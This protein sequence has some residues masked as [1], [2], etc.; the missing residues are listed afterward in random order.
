MSEKKRFGSR[1]SSIFG[2]N[3]SN[4]KKSQPNTI[5]SSV[6][7]SLN[8]PS[9]SLNSRSKGLSTLSSPNPKPLNKT[10]LRNHA[11]SSTINSSQHNSGKSI[12]SKP[13]DEALRGS[14]SNNHSLSLPVNS[15]RTQHDDNKNFSY[16]SQ[17]NY[18]NQPHPRDQSINSSST[19]ISQTSIYPNISNVSVQLSPS[20]ENSK[21]DPS[22]SQSRNL[23]SPSPEPPT[24]HKLRR[25]PPSELDSFDFGN[26]N[27]NPN[28]QLQSPQLS[29][30]SKQSPQDRDQ[31]SDREVPGNI[32]AD[33]ESEIDHFLQMEDSHSNSNDLSSTYS[34]RKAISNRN[35]NNYLEETD[36]IQNEFMNDLNSNTRNFTQLEDPVTDFHL[37]R[38]RQE[39]PYPINSNIASPDD[40][41]TTT[42]TE[43]VENSPQII[44][45]YMMDTTNLENIN[46]FETTLASHA[47][48]QHFD[49]SS[50]NRSSNTSMTSPITQTK[51][52]YE[53]S[54]APSSSNVATTGV[55]STRSS[56]SRAT[57]GSNSRTRPF[58]EQSPS[59]CHSTQTSPSLQL[60][61][62]QRQQQVQQQQVQQQ[63]P[64]PHQLQQPQHLPLQQVTQTLPTQQISTKAPQL[65]HTKTENS[66]FSDVSSMKNFNTAGSSQRTYHRTSSSIGSI[67][68]SNSYRNVNL[69]T[70]KKTL[71]L[72][73]G[74]G[75]RSNYVLTIRRNAG[76]A[77]NE[78]GPSKWKLPVGIL[79]IDKTAMKDNSNGKYKR[80][81][82]NSNNANYRKK[83]SGVELKHGHLK[84]RLLA[85]EIDEGDDYSTSIT[86]N[87]TSPPIT[88][89][90]STTLKNATSGP[91]S[92]STKASR[93]N[94][95]KRTTTDGSLLTGDTQSLDS[96]NT[97]ST[98]N[99]NNGP[100]LNRNDSIVSS[101]SSGSISEKL[102]TGYYQ[103][104]GYKYGEIDDYDYNGSKD[105]RVD[106]DDDDATEMS[107]NCDNVNED[108]KDNNLNNKHHGNIAHLNGFG[109]NGFVNNDTEIEDRPKLVLANPDYSSDSD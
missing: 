42:P 105:N 16:T 37:T 1:I 107:D 60:Q 102:T 85:A 56:Y 38:S 27:S 55:A 46:P 6:N 79:P 96:T 9:S 44:Q 97:E 109:N 15:H 64:Q 32:M 59:I 86:L 17:E 92:F 61:E 108:M 72:K 41:I 65:Q 81:A 33:L 76:T 48:Y 77:F 50:S 45:N 21:F 28:S 47:N 11:S 51:Q 91:Q 62:Q 43:S 100:G 57:T 54:I 2:Q 89:S 106:E 10:P 95:L 24:T 7:S 49:S 25:K 58:A 53:A 78:S 4:D 84:P 13:S 71:S 35:S 94:S 22:P 8:V 23:T 36:A 74:E 18:H 98:K 63:Q 93:E 75:E 73:P 68:S 30:R 20:S 66:L 5:P 101:D 90:S 40:S 83:T 104:R 70:L 88:N 39:A 26:L 19:Q 82:G 34:S 80:L 52:Y 103:H 3:S 87:K 12:N 29:S 69:A 31:S 14:T 67:R 99:H